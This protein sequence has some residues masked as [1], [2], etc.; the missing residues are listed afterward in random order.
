[1]A[2]V[3]GPVADLAVGE[4]LDVG[5]KGCGGDVAQHLQLELQGVVGRGGGQG[6]A[7]H[8]LR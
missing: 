7:G 5:L 6:D 2:V 1:M 4:T 8:L 3:L